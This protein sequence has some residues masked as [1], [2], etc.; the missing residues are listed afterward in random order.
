[1]T[2]IEWTDQ[3][4]NPVAGCTPVSSGC[5]NCYAALGWSGFN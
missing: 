3:T 5:A 2:R 4:W 1:M